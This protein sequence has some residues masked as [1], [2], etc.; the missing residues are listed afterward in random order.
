MTSWEN[1]SQ[2]D[3]GV[4][5]TVGQLS[6][7]ALLD[8]LT[9]TGTKT[10]VVLLRRDTFEKDVV[11]QIQSSRPQAVLLP[12]AERDLE[13]KQ[14]KA[15]A[16]GLKNLINMLRRTEMVHFLLG[17]T[18]DGAEKPCSETWPVGA[19]WCYC[20]GSAAAEPSFELQ[21]GRGF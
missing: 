5:F 6:N 7:H 18:R 15:H 17:G 9:Q 13:Q 3:A 14:A 10:G 20:C 12:A 2:E 11:G 8:P 19:T 4:D 1:G 21:G 16:K